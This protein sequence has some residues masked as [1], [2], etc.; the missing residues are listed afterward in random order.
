MREDKSQEVL[1]ST[2]VVEVT[3]VPN[4]HPVKVRSTTFGTRRVPSRR[5]EQVNLSVNLCHVSPRTLLVHPR[6]P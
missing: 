5:D 6:C 3:G 2:Y 1:E 4:V